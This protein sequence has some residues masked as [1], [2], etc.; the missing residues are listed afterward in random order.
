MCRV[1][2][3]VI[4]RG[5]YWVLSIAIYGLVWPT[6]VWPTL[7]WPTHRVSRSAFLPQKDLRNWKFIWKSDVGN[8]RLSPSQTVALKRDANLENI[9][10]RKH[11]SQ[12]AKEWEQGTVDGQNIRLT[13]FEHSIDD[14]CTHL[15]PARTCDDICT[16]MWRHL[17]VHVTTFAR[18]C[19]DICTYMW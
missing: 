18:T 5:I 9:P 17:H 19:D 11:P 10:H 6:L 8:D 1:M 12:T 15:K 4:C 2:S 13:T 16:Y 14:I 3:W 7:V